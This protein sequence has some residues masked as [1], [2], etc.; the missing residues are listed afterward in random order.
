MAATQNTI[1]YYIYPSDIEFVATLIDT[2]KVVHEYTHADCSIEAH[3]SKSCL[4]L[5][6][7]IGGTS[8][9]LKLNV[10]YCPHTFYSYGY[11]TSTDNYLD[12]SYFNKE[13][14]TT[15]E[16]LYAY[17]S[18]NNDFETI[19]IT[20]NDIENNPVDKWYTKTGKDITNCIYNHAGK[21]IEAGVEMCFENPGNSQSQNRA[22]PYKLLITNGNLGG[23]FDVLINDT[24]VTSIG[25]E[26]LPNEST[27]RDSG[28]SDF[29][30]P[31]YTGDVVTINNRKSAGSWFDI[32]QNN[33]TTTG[34]VLASKSGIYSEYSEY[35]YTTNSDI[36][37]DV[38]SSYYC[39]VLGDCNI[40]KT[41]GSITSAIS[42]KVGDK[43]MGYNTRNNEFCEVTVLSVIKKQRKELVTI[44]LT[45]GIVLKC[46]PDHPI[47]TNLGWACYDPKTS[48]YN[49][50]IEGLLELTK[51]MT[52]L[53]AD[54]KYVKIANIEYNIL[55]DLIPT[56]TFNTTPGIDTFIAENCVV[57]NACEPL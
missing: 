2:D 56:Y 8:G 6:A 21:L 44:T 15:S 24:K 3:N 18:S 30:Y 48:V 1:N 55:P 41:D 20:T 4:K 54:N 53:T 14:Y 7:T 52:V 10:P 57:H 47:Y 9:T 29:Y 34:L 26:T 43:L 27:Y 32:T 36:L 11:Y 22:T 40:T 51:D 25:A 13:E 37:I 42:V 16:R 17:K 28:I 46:T 50:S 45:N 31:I 38:T 39:C 49:Q 35:K 5:A 12:L 19:Y 33:K 23:G